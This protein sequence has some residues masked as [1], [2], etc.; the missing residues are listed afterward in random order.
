MPR[1]AIIEEEECIGCTRCINAC[2]FDAIEMN[3]QGN[4]AIVIE[5]YCRGCMRCAPACPTGAIKRG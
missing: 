1:L 4:K 3:Q 2:P 5:D